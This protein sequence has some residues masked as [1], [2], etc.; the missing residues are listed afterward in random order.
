VRDPQEFDTCH[1]AGA[2]NIPV[3]QLVHRVSELTDGRTP[4]F[5][6]RSGRRSLTACAL[7]IRAGIGAPAHLEGGLLA[8]AAEV[9]PTFEVAGG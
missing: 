6:C 5:L 8:W 2:R 7:A 3:A 1:L 4:V 9:D